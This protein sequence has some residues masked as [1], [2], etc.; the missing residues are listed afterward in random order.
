MLPPLEPVETPYTWE[1]HIG[2]SACV[3]TGPGAC[4]SPPVPLGE[5]DQWTMVDGRP[6]AA[7]MVLTW[8]AETPLTEELYFSLFAVRSC[9]NGCTEWSS[10][11][12]NVAV[13]GA[14]P[15]AIDTGNLRLAE[16]EQLAIFVGQPDHCR[17]AVVVMGCLG[18]VEQ[19]FKVDGM[20]T[21]LVPAA[22]T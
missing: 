4:S 8:S 11:M 20:L 18:A 6:V 5:S 17:G 21:M 3:P 22:N 10:E 2:R 9:G 16:D 1:G 12:F 15:L 14:S 13:T 7:S 19:S